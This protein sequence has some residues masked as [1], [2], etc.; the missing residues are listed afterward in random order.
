MKCLS[1]FQ[2]RNYLYYGPSLRKSL[3]MPILLN[4]LDEILR[5]GL[6]RRLAFAF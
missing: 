5:V 6:V 3:H 4:L 1:D 2:A